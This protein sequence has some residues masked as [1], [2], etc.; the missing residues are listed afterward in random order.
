LP[1]LN[2]RDTESR[3]NGE[4]AKTRTGKFNKLLLSSASP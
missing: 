3:E 1:F 2:H 4:P